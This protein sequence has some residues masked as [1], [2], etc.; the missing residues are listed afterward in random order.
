MQHVQY[1]P[2]D[3]APSQRNSEMFI[4]PCQQAKA[5]NS[6]AMMAQFWS[7]LDNIGG[8]QIFCQHNNPDKP[9]KFRIIRFPR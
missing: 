6:K 5:Q 1:G 2:Q 4:S 7:F 3:I 9:E 8:A